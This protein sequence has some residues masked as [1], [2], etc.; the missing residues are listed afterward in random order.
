MQFWQPNCLTWVAAVDVAGFGGTNWARIEAARRDGDEIF[1]RFLIGVCQL[2]TVCALF[3][4]PA[5]ASL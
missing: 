4:T 3:A 5:R 2:L 1:A